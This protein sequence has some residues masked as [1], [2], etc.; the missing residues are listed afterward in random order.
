MQRRQ[1]PVRSKE[2]IMLGSA[3]T[4]ALSAVRPKRAEIVEGCTAASSSKRAMCCTGELPTRGS[5]MR[6]AASILTASG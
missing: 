2:A 4:L 6:S 1:R 5:I 3:Q